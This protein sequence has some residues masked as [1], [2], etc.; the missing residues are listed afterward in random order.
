MAGAYFEHGL[1]SLNARVFSCAPFC[2][3]FVPLFD[4]C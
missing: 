1:V 4:R 3:R 2:R